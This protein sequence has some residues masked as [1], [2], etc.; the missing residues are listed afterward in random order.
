MT[1]SSTSPEFDQLLLE[2]I[3][4]AGRIHDRLA[5]GEWPEG[6]DWGDV[7]DMAETVRALRAVSDRLFAEGGYAPT[8]VSDI[9]GYLNEPWEGD[10]R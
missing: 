6:L 2:A 10:P 5:D 9:V 4:I 1:A 7:G 3:D 8:E